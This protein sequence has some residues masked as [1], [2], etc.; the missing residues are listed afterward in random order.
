MG[1]EIRAKVEVVNAAHRSFNNHMKKIYKREVAR[2]EMEEKIK[3]NGGQKLDYFK[4][5]SA[6]RC[7]RL[8]RACLSDQI[9]HLHREI[10]THAPK[11]FGCHGTIQMLEPQLVVSRL[12]WITASKKN[13][14]RIK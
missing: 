12:A 6:A 4:L 8:N 2:E 13:Y 5:C 9:C 7:F 1:E 14:S 11:E 10:P 3:E